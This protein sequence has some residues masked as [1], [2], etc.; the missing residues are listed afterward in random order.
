MAP[1]QRALDT[2]DAIRLLRADPRRASLIEDS[3]LTPDVAASAERFAQSA[4]FRTVMTLVGDLPGKRLVDIGSGNGIASFAFAGA[5]ARVFAVEPN[6]S[7]EF[8][9]GAVRALTNSLDV[10][11]V[12]GTGEAIPLRSES[13]DVVYGRQ[14]LHHAGDLR[15]FIAECARVLR[16]NGVFIATREHVA[17]DARQLRQFLCNHAVHQ[18]AGGEHAYPLSTYLEAIT[19]AGFAEPVTLGPWD[20]VINAFPTA[21]NAEELSHLPAVL[22]KRFFGVTGAVAAFVPGVKTLIWSLLRRPRPGR[23]YTFVARRS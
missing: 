14:V 23:M 8:G 7:T 11:V 1:P 20:S 13:V 15:G 16:R 5:G 21:R 2:D 3:Y 17:D 10:V 22:L 4:E 6:L 19:A 9:A 12:A 18:L